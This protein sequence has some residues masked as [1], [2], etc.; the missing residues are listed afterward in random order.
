M[1]VAPRYHPSEWT[2]F[3]DGIFRYKHKGTGVIR[4]SLTSIGRKLMKT[5]FEKA[6]QMVVSKTE[7]KMKKVTEK[8]LEKEIIPEEKKKETTEKGLMKIDDIL[9]KKPSRPI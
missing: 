6:S 8:A 1:H 7:E 5:A 2:K 3:Y 4:D 9:R